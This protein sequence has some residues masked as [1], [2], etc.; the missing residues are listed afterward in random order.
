[1]SDRICTVCKIEFKYPYLLERHN[2]NKIKCTN[3]QD[4]NLICT[5]CKKHYV[6]KYTL[7]RHQIT[8]KSKNNI[9]IEDNINNNSNNYNNNSNVVSNNIDKE[10]ILDSINTFINYMNDGAK[11]ENYNQKCVLTLQNILDFVTK[12]NHTQKKITK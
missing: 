10:N 11:N 5:N 4:N 3:Y 2:K 7:I 1:M 6:S 9:V 8:C 12:I